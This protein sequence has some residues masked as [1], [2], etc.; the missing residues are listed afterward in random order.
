VKFQKLIICS[1]I[2]V[3]SYTSSIFSQTKALKSITKKDLRT[4]LEFVAA[5]EFNGRETP[6]VELE[7]CNLYLANLVKGYGL[8]PILSDGSY[9]QEIPVNVS[10]VSDARSR[11]RIISD[12]SEQNYYYQKGFGGSF[13]SSGTFSGEV[14]FVGYGLHA[15]EQGWNDY[16]NIDCSG[17]IVVLLDGQL[18]ENHELREIANR[19]WRD[20]RSYFPNQLGAAG[21]LSIIN[22][23]REKK[24]AEGKNIFYNTPRGR[25][26]V[27]FE[28]QRSSR[29]SRPSQQQ[30]S[31]QQPQRPSLPFGQAEISHD[32]ATS[33]LGISK[34]ELNNMFAKISRGE[35]I[36][37]KDLSSK[38]VELNIVTETKRDITRSVLAFVEGS[39]PKLKNEYVVVCAHQDHLGVRNGEIIN[40]ADDNGSGTVALLEIA[41][42]LMIE[43]PKR[44][45]ITAWFT[46]EERG[47]MGSQYF[48]NNCPVP[49]EKI[50]TCLNMDMLSRNDPDSLYLVASD[51]LSSELDGS[52]HKMNKKYKINFGFSYIYSNRTHP[53]RVYYRSDQYPHIR[54]G[55]PSVWFF[56]GF[57]PD[58]HTPRDVLEFVDYDKMLKATKLVY[59][60]AYDI[61]N[62]KS[63]LK[64]DVNPEVTS[65]GKHNLPVE[66]IR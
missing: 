4:H 16:E 38:H 2:L 34:S 37:G 59:L 43:R 50:S 62:K 17:K 30:S 45:V 51:L 63:L 53:Q 3:L 10:T 11:L 54:F 25:M 9:Y 6:S 19:R 1:V 44:S 7:I 66:S 41:Q 64:L 55:I 39:D 8:K 24:R 23:E 57:T 65:R 32:V 31:Q 14:V 40:G 12:V 58:Y 22:V 28:S 20:S 27:S 42:A 13:R 18:P 26:A 29:S 36:Q 46:G 52:I 47:Y 21:V 15:P 35:K 56:C 61:G 60:T 48:V 5:D 49:I 33:L